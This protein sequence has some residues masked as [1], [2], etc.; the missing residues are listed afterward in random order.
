MA[1]G[2]DFPAA[3]FAV[4]MTGALL[5]S[6]DG[7]LR[8]Q[9]MQQL[10]ELVL[11]GAAGHEVVAWFDGLPA[12]RVQRWPTTIDQEAALL[13]KLHKVLSDENHFQVRA[14]TCIHSRASTVRTRQHHC[15]V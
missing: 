4:R 15:G 2:R 1:H 3:A 9:S 8:Q 13:P 7:M 5:D 10:R 11:G 14:S 12:A 6:G